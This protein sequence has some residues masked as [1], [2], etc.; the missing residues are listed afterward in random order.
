VINSPEVLKKLR[1]SWERKFNRNVL[2]GWLIIAALVAGISVWVGHVV[3]SHP[4]AGDLASLP[5]IGEE[6]HEM[7]ARLWKFKIPH[8]DAVI[9]SYRYQIGSDLVRLTVLLSANH[10]QN[11]FVMGVE[12]HPDTVE[13]GVD[14]SNQAVPPEA[15]IS[16]IDAMLPDRATVK[17]SSLPR[18][19]QDDA[20][21]PTH[22]EAS[23]FF[24]ISSF[25][26]RIGQR[27]FWDRHGQRWTTGKCPDSPA[28]IVQVYDQRSDE[29]ITRTGI[30]SE[31]MAQCLK[32]VF[33]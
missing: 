30:Y 27:Y 2:Q 3:L 23:A 26:R 17:I 9:P 33:Y 13:N 6:R 5:R 10:D 28:G 11:E 15:R 20:S 4:P 22:N 1:T 16:I 8:P 14:L 24:I 32:H 18:V 25:S 19:V 31:Y 29:V 12:I 21:T 7:Q